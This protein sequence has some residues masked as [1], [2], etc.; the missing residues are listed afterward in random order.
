MK[1][2]SVIR[3]KF[4]LWN[5]KNDRQREALQIVLAAIETGEELQTA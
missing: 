2:Q 1:N 3:L 4:L 5:T